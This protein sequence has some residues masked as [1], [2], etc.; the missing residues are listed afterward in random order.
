MIIVVVIVLAAI[1]TVETI[2]PSGLPFLTPAASLALT[3]Q[4]TF[5]FAKMLMGSQGTD[6][7]VPKVYANYG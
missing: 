4:G 2:S 5:R 7:S 3:A 6:L 1:L